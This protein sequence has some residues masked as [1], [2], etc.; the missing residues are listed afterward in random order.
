MR[1]TSRTFKIVAGVLSIIIIFIVSYYF[2]SNTAT[3]NMSNMSDFIDVVYYINLDHREDRKQQ[4]LEEMNKINFP[5]EKIER[6]SAVYMKDRGHLGCSMS[7]IKAVER[8]IASDHN[9]CIIFEDDF[10]FSQD[11]ETVVSA[12]Q[13][14]FDNNVDFDVCMLSANE[15]DIQPIPQ[16]DFIKKVNYA[17]T[18]SGY[19][20]TKKIAP[21]LLANFKEGKEN[22]EESYNQNA[23]GSKDQAYDGQYAVDQYWSI[24]QKTTNWFMFNPKLGKQRSSFSDIM[25]GNVSYGL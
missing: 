1:K 4:F 21:I 8:F 16:Y 20:L 23:D 24:I 19:M 14:F 3:E 22:L 13:T 18:A 11:P 17:A 25:Q 2:A 6:I 15:Y 7:H 5:Q 10:E 12:I 9:I